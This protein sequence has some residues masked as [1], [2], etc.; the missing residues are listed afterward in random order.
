V[1]SLSKGWPFLLNSGRVRHDKGAPSTIHRT[2]GAGGGMRGCRSS[3]RSLWGSTA[4]SRRFRDL[5]SEGHPYGPQTKNTKLYRLSKHRLSAKLVRGQRDGS[6]R[7]YSRFSRP[8]PLH[9]LSSSSSIVFTRLSGPRSRL[10]LLR[11][12]GSAGNRSRTS[13]SVAKNS[14]H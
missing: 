12:S 8:G 11:K 9:F 4:R 10:I 7:A 6:L 2:T 1:F 3:V 14:D 5:S 13:G